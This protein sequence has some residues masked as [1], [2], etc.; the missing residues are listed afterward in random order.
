MGSKPFLLF[1]GDLFETEVEFIRLK[2]ILIGTHTLD[3]VLS[4]NV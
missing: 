2:N 4:K 3:L 1:A